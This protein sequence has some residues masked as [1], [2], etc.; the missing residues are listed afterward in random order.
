VSYLKVGHPDY[1]SDSYLLE[2]EKSSKHQLMQ[3][4]IAKLTFLNIWILLEATYSKQC[5]VA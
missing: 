5:D 2:D 1:G 3:I 4:M